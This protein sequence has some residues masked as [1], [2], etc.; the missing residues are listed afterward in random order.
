MKRRVGDCPS[1][2]AT[3]RSDETLHGLGKLKAKGQRRGMEYPGRMTPSRATSVDERT[4]LRAVHGPDLGDGT[5]QGL[6]G[7]TLGLSSYGDPVDMGVGRVGVDIKLRP[8][9]NI[10][11]DTL[12]ES[13]SIPCGCN[14]IRGC[15]RK[16]EI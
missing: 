15:T 3:S 8:R 9:L 2:D 10:Y 1:V 11:G 13:A 4:A 14:G 5:N 6:T 7:L 16:R 12:R